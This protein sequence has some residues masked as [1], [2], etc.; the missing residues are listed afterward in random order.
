M[1][2]HCIG[3][4]HDKRLF[5]DIMAEECGKRGYVFIDHWDEVLYK[6]ELCGHHTL[7]DENYDPDMK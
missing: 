7:N 4:S 6:N 2:L 5:N 1:K 3:D